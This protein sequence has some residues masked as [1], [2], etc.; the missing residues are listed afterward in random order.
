[1]IENKDPIYLI[2][3]SDLTHEIPCR[4]NE[5]EDYF[6]VQRCDGTILQKYTHG[7][8]SKKLIHL[9][10]YDKYTNGSE[11]VEKITHVSCMGDL[12]NSECGKT[13]IFYRKSYN[14][15]CSMEYN[16]FN[17]MYKKVENEQ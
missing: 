12:N 15:V 17:R 9:F 16:T 2:K 1:M 14:E 5:Q 4:Y 7:I 8:E 11:I 10:D 3:C 13:K 6:Y